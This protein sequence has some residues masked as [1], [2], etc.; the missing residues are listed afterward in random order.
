MKTT[1]SLL[2]G[3]ASSLLLTVG[4]TRAAERFDV[5]DPHAQTQKMHSDVAKSAELLNAMRLCLLSG[6]G[7]GSCIQIKS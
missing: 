2:L 3:L 5:S 6:R 4:L 7:H 1:S